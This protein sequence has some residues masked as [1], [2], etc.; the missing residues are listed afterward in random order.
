[1]S[2][3]YIQVIATFTR[4][5]SDYSFSQHQLYMSCTKT[6]LRSL[7]Q[8]V[9]RLILPN[10][11]HHGQICTGT[12]RNLPG[13]NTTIVEKI[14]AIMSSY[15]QSEFNSDLNANFVWFLQTNNLMPQGLETN[16]SFV[17]GLRR[18]SELSARDPMY[19]IG[20]G[21]RYQTQ[22]TMGALLP[23]D[24]SSRTSRVAVMNRM[25]QQ[26]TQNMSSIGG[27]VMQTVRDFNLVDENRDRPHIETMR[28]LY[29]S[30]V[31]HAYE[32]LWKDLNE[33]HEAHKR[34]EQDALAS[35]RRQA[36]R[37]AEAAAQDR[38]RFE[39]ERRQWL[40]EKNRREGQLATAH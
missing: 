31:T 3:P 10:T 25:K 32:N 29:K 11:H 19:A 39:A 37:A 9:N 7:D 24:N 5:G 1:M 12:M 13:T 17:E 26:I 15:W 40:E 8:Q 30:M 4:S 18:W 34:A 35:A 20:E 27:S 38:V 6:P 21:V 2:L 22:S 33:S 28:Q 36:E 16:V 23:G 14:E